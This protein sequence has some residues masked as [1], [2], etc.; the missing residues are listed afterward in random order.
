MKKKQT[1]GGA[2]KG[3]GR[4]PGS[5]AGRTV[6]TSSVSLPPDLWDKLDAIRGELTRSA[7]VAAKIKGTRK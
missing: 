7:W 1:R 4:K 2:R 5:G 3:A 6:I